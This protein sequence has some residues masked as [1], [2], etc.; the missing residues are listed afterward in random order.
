MRRTALIGHVAC[1]ARLGSSY[2]SL[3]R[4]ESLKAIFLMTNEDVQIGA[5]LEPHIALQ[6]I[7]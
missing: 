3:K 4:G 5:Q 2:L 6:S 1:W 7:Q